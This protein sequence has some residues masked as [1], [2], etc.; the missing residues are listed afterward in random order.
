MSP[1][2]AF[3]RWSLLGGLAAIALV[4]AQANAVGGFAGL[5]QVGEESAVR[6]AIETQLGDIPLAPHSGHDGQ[7]SYA[8]GLDLLGEEVPELLDHGAYRYRRILYPAVSSLFGLLE[9]EAL[10]TGMIMV[11]V[12]SAGAAS[13]LTASIGV[14]QGWSD[15]VALVVVLNPGIW[16]SVRLLTSDTMALALMLIGLHLFLSGR[17][18]AAAAFSLSTLAKDA[19]LVTPGGLAISRDRRR[20]L[21]LIVPVAVLAVWV[22]WLT[23]TMGE[24]FTGRG[25]LD[26]P[27]V[28]FV[29]AFPIWRGLDPAELLYLVFALASVALGLVYASLVKSWLRWS[30]LGWSVLGVVSSDWVW[31]L[32][33]NAARVFAPIVV[34][35]ALAE[36]AR[37]G[38]SDPMQLGREDLRLTG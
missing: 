12:I 2:A 37:R 15:W 17:P 18:A 16:L 7:I 28:G 3:W 26:L 24:G 10:L 13:G 1:R 22:V 20:W 36:A 4:V 14:R 6:T 25:N 32:G 29:D 34:L 19:Y 9:G 33:N 30:I 23:V 27:F 8:I 11:T 21:L 5:L 38:T 35:V 31:D